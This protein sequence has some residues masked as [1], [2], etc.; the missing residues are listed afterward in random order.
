MTLQKKLVLTFVVTIITLGTL[1]GYFSYQ[2]A[3][4]IVMTN[5]K[6]EMADTINRIDININAKVRGMTEVAQ[7]LSASRSMI[8][9]LDEDC[10]IKDKTKEENYIKESFDNFIRAFEAVSNIIIVDNIGKIQYS[11]N[12]QDTIKNQKELKK[13][14]Q[15]AAQKKEKAIWIGT[16]ESLCDNKIEEDD[17]VITMVKSILNESGT[18]KLGLLV[19]ELNPDMFSNLLLSNQ[20]MFQNQYTFIVD[21][22]GDVICSNKKMKHTWLNNMEENFEKGIRKFELIWEEKTYYVCGQYNGV[23]GWKTFSAVSLNDFFPQSSVLRKSIFTLVVISVVLASAVIML[24]AYTMTKPMNDLSEAMKE[25]QEGNFELQLPSNRK[26]EIGHLIRSFNF[27]IN[28]INTLIKEVYQEKIAQK[29]AE[30]EALQAQINPHFLYN[31]LDSINWMLIEKEEYD[32]S[33][34]IISLGDLMKYSIHGKDSLVPLEEELDYILS[35]LRIQKNRLEHRL[36][37]EIIIAEEIKGCFVPKLLLQPLVE[38]AIL[39]G[40]EPKKGG[41]KIVIEGHEE[42]SCISISVSDNGEGIKGEELTKLIHNIHRK[43]E[44]NESIGVQNVDRRIRL[45]FG[46]EYGLNIKSKWKE[47][48]TITLSIP[49]EGRK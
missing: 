1:I 9:I 3:E 38:N 48:T 15:V 34:I 26:D 37:Y 7:N 43:E 4:R 23:T 8:S 28:K 32:I 13:Y 10:E 24:L 27:M 45:H 30:L 42:K 21:K 20:S 11:Y 31:T 17:F 33:E 41:G 44:G 2:D 46:E 35:Y 22:K 19:V 16:A 14:V 25:V 47:G 49:K 5:K 12:Q 36:E 39:H 18:K 29:N 6:S 40:I